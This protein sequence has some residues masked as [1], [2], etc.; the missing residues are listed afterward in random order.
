MLNLINIYLL[1]A[2]WFSTQKSYYNLFFFKSKLVQFA[3]TILN[4]SE[5]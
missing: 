2:Y 3:Q 4:T 5:Y 1:A